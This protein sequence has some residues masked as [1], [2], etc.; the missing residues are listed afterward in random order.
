MPATSSPAAGSKSLPIKGS[1]FL[2]VGGASLVGSASAEVLL[3]EGAA[4]VTILDSFF[5]GSTDNIKHLAGD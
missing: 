5:Q 3:R 1:R 4:E 2:I